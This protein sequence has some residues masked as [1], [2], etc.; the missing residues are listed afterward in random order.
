MDQSYKA[1]SD[2]YDSV[3][4]T[5]TEVLKAASVF[6]HD[7]G[8]DESLIRSYWLM[9]FDWTLTDLVRNLHHP[10]ASGDQTYF[11]QVLQRI[12]DDEPIQYILG[13]ADFRGH[14]Y[15]VTPAVLIPREDSAGIIDWA[16]R[17]SQKYGPPAQIVDIGTGSGILAIELALSFP[18][19]QVWGLDIS[20]PALK[21]AAKNGA[22]HGVKVKWLESDLLTAMK[23]VDQGGMAFDL[24]VSNPPYI[25]Q[26]ELELMDASVK[27]YEPALA[28]YADQ[29]GYAIYQRLARQLPQYSNDRTIIILEIGYRQGAGVVALMES[30][31]PNH[32]VQLAQ[33]MSGHDRYVVIQPE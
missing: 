27:K 32:Q 21:V 3:Q 11:R 6:L 13:R 10:V 30:A 9:V 19:S 16:E 25:G 15:Q 29:Q 23:D 12:V 31:F 7:Q 17:L 1:A 28:L 24:I 5:L 4:P 14:R 33:D 22:Q 26:D 18:H 2:S 8:H 20:R